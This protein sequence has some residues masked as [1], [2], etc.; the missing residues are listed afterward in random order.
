LCRACGYPWYEPDAADHQR[1]RELCPHCAYRTC[2]RCRRIGDRVL[3]DADGAPHC[4]PCIAAIRDERFPCCGG[5]TRLD[6]SEAHR[7]ECALGHESAARQQ[8]ALR[9]IL[10]GRVAAAKRRKPRR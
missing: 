9:L 3:S 2:F 10:G 5:A 4:D 6:G 1:E 8:P 7:P